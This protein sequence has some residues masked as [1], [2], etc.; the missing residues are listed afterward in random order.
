MRPG[1]SSERSNEY[2]HWFETQQ[3]CTESECYRQTTDHL[4]SPDI[5]NLI[6][7]YLDLETLQELAQVDPY[8]EQ[9]IADALSVAKRAQM[10][11]KELNNGHLFTWDFVHSLV[12]GSPD[13]NRDDADTRAAELALRE[14]VQDIPIGSFDERFF[15]RRN[16]VLEIVKQLLSPT[17]YSQFVWTLLQQHGHMTWS[18]ASELDMTDTSWPKRFDFFGRQNIIRWW[19]R[20]GN[21]SPE[22]VNAFLRTVLER[23]DGISIFIPLDLYD[24]IGVV[25]LAN[26]QSKPVHMNIVSNNIENQQAHFPDLLPLL[27]SAIGAMGEQKSLVRTSKEKDRLLAA[28]IP[29]ALHVDEGPENANAILSAL[30]DAGILSQVPL[31]ATTLLNLL[32]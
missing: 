5:V 26:N 21:H 28:L 7:Q 18:L 16:F 9:D 6:G 2:K 14:F 4:E 3:E 24:Q 8:T 12:S 27:L 25:L 20:R 1:L 23:P 19:L 22:Q 29:H 11:K 17:E 13:G 31:S 10:I 30:T 32:E 15:L